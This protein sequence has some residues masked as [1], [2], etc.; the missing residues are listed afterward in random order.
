MKT[1]DLPPSVIER[2]AIVYV[3]QSTTGQVT[4]NLESQRSQYALVDVARAFGFRDIVTIDE[5]LGRSASGT[6]SRPGFESL[7]AQ[8]C[9]GVVG[10]VF[11]LEA[12][13]LARNGRDWHHLLELCGLVGARV[14]DSDGA[15]DPSVPNDRLLLGLKGT[16]SEF[17]L[18]L[19]RRRLVD[20]ARAKAARG[21]LRVA[22]P[23]G[24]RWTREHGLEMDPD[25]RVQEAI[26]TILSLFD[27]FESARKV[28]LYMRAQELLVPRPA[29]GK[30]ATPFQW[31]LPVYRSVLAVLQNPFYAGA[32]AYGKS[33]SRTKLAGGRLAKSHGHSRPMEKWSVLLRDHHAAYLDWAAFERNQERLRRNAFRCASGGPKS[34]RG[35]R[36]LLTG[37]LRCA[38]CGRMLNVTYTGC[39]ER[40]A[41]YVCRT[42]QT[43]HGLRP[44]I[45][46]SARR[47]DEVIAN[48]LLRVVEPLAIEATVTA[49]RQIE[50]R[51][52]ERVRALQL[53]CEQARYDVQL[54]ARR[55][56]AV[57][58]GNRLVASELEARWNVAIA[59]LNECE[60]RLAAF[61][62]TP[63]VAPDVAP[64]ERLARDLPAVWNA[65][66]TSMDIK[67][68][69]LRTLVEEIL[70][71]VDASK[72]EI[73][74]VIHWK[75]G[76]HS[77]LRA[78]KPMS[79]EH[80]RRAPTAAD[81]LIREMAGTW[82]DE[83][84]AATLNRLGLRT[85]Q[86][87]TW[88][89]QLVESGRCTA[90]IAAYPTAEDPCD[91]V[92]M[93]DAATHAGVSPYFI[94][95]LILR[96]VLPAKQ[97]VPDAPWQIRR[98]DLETDAVRAAIAHRHS[99]PRPRE[100][101]RDDAT[102]RIPGT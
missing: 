2:R 13:R 30:H 50:E 56:E 5:D 8:L 4:D 61:A 94:R 29:D 39:R 42:G 70:V 21:E 63:K 1:P 49:L 7:V 85:E 71:D 88:T 86:A 22:V 82:S 6:V 69:L 81:Q 16:M 89:K 28:L 33:D 26:R 9:Q 90:G 96:G 40:L 43:T 68:R 51:D 80:S 78:P 91:W 36:A 19:L 17:E 3:R 76:Q 75:G 93:R 55:Y 35:G 45:H 60:S 12:S 79:G 73:V 46:F 10:A 92:T 98:A 102:R 47:P 37:L 53:E 38:R 48:E 101:R 100:A 31:T 11:C 15:Y 41:R 67:Q 20:G 95:V 58:P 83:H 24:Y 52:Q 18:T 99:V 34:A 65:T 77:E 14:I 27:R 97:V 59:R 54:A 25:L 57:D 66:T 74:L 44:C 32:Y 72:R 64:L 84:I 87:Q 23:V 62:Q